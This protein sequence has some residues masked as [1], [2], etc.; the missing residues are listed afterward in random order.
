MV[1]AA[2]AADGRRT[3]TPA[4]VVV[5]N[6]RILAVDTP[7][8]IGAHG[9]PVEDLGQRIVLPAL[10]NAHAHLDLTT[11]GPVPLDGGGFDGWL[12]EIRTRRP[13]T[14]GATDEAV[15]KGVKAS[16]DGGVV[17][18]GDIAGAF[19]IDA[20]RSLARSALAGVSFIELFGI[21]A[22]LPAGLEALGRIQ[23]VLEAESLDRPGFRIGLSPHAPYSCGPDLYDA[24]AASGRPVTTHLAETPE[25]ATL[26]RTGR[27]PLL[28]LLRSIGAY[29]PQEHPGDQ[30]TTR[31]ELGSHPIEMLGGCRPS[32]PWL[33]AH[34]NYLTELDE[35]ASCLDARL[36][37]LRALNATVVFCPRA[38]RFLGHPRPGRAS[39]PWR[40]LLDA[41]VPVALGT[42]GLPCLD[43]PDRITPLDDV[44]LLLGEGAP[45]HATIEMATIHAARGL[46]LRAEAVTFDGGCAAGLLAIKGA[47][48]QREEVAMTI[49]GG[50]DLPDWVIPPRPESLEPEAG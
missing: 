13:D 23:R 9:L 32:R 18:V 44:R 43:T 5:E 47:P 50:R 46:G 36:E 45:L 10:V 35:P 30:G 40:R 14:A 21:G 41:G 16:L 15:T 1:L 29:G 27:G 24:I 42:D 33:L 49:A 19:G 37:I 7:E 20:A 26:L 25:E 48:R 22:R 38:A 17:A 3:I 28:D 2:A 34:V 12:A 4:A 39:H 11:V 31:F 6:G 8:T